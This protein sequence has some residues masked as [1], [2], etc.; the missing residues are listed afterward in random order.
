MKRGAHRR[1]EELDDK[2]VIKK[3]KQRIAE[4][5]KEVSQLSQQAVSGGNRDIQELKVPL[6]TNWFKVF[7]LLCIYTG[8]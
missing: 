5:E 2:I 6:P 4:L 8:S 3:L 7:T 1:N